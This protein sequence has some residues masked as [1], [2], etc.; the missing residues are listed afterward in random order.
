[1]IDFCSYNIRGLNNKVQ[2]VSDFLST[3]NIS[4]VGLL[5]TRVKKD[6]AKK[7][8]SEINSSFCW[9]D[10]YVNH[11][12]GRI[13][14]GWNHFVWDLK[15]L[16]QSA[17]HITCFM[18]H[19]L[20]GTDF[21]IS[22]VYGSNSAIE[23]RDLWSDLLS[24]SARVKNSAWILSGD[25]NICKD[26]SEKHGGNVCWTSEMGE[27]K[28]AVIRLGITDLRFGGNLFTWCDGNPSAPIFRKLDRTMVNADWLTK[29]G[30]SSSF[31]PNRGFSDHSPATT[32]LGLSRNCPPKPFK[33]F[34]FLCEH[35]DFLTV[36]AQCWETSIVGDPWFVLTSKLKLVKHA[37]K[38]LNRR[39][40]NVHSNVSSNRAALCLHQNSLSTNSSAEY[41]SEEKRLLAEFKAS[42]AVEESFLKQ[43]SRVQWL[44]LGDSNN[45]YFYNACKSKWNTNKILALADEDGVTQ[46]S[47]TDISLVA[48]KYFKNLYS[49]HSA[50]TTIPEDLSLPG[51]SQ[52]QKDYVSKPFSACEVFATLK[53]MPKH[54]A[55]GPDGFTV[56]FF[57]KAWQIVGPDVTTAIL[58]FFDS[59][60]MPRIVNSVAIAL[61]PKCENPSNM[62]DFRPISCCNILYKC[63]AKMLSQRLKC[64]LQSIISPF[65]SAFIPHRSLGDNVMLVQSLCKDYHINRG[66]PRCA[67]K[68]DIHKAFD[69]LNWDF[70]FNA[71]CRMNFP[72]GFVFWIKRCVTSA[73]FSVKINGSLEG[74]F[75]GYSGLRQGDPLSPYLFILAMEVLSACLKKSTCSEYF[76]FHW[77]TKDIGL[78]H[79]IFADD[80]F[81]F[82]RGD[83]ASV[84]CLNEGLSLFS[85]LSGLVP[86]W[87]KSS[88]FFS[89]VDASTQSEIL[90]V[91]GFQGGSLP[92]TYLGLPLITSKL[93]A[94]DCQPLIAKFCSKIEVWTA[95]LLSFAGRL[96]LIKYVLNGILGFWSTYIFLPKNILKRLNA[97]MFKFLW[98]GFYKPTGRCHYKVK[99][100]ECCLP[101][102]EGGLGLRNIFEWNFSAILHQLWRIVQ[103]GSTSI[104]VQWFTKVFLKNKGFWT[105]GIPYKCSWVARKIL[106]CRVKASE[107]I[108]YHIGRNSRFLFWLDPWVQN[109]PLLARFGTNAVS[110]FESSQR[111]L[112]SGFLFDGAWSFPPSNHLSCIEIRQA[113]GSVQIHDSDHVSW[114]SIVSKHVKISSIWNSSRVHGAQVVWFRDVWNL[115]SIPKCSFI[116][117]LALKNRLLTR[118]RMILLE[119]QSPADCV[120]CSGEESAQHLFSDCPFFDLVRRNSPIAFS[121]NWEQC[122]RGDIFSSS[123]DN[124]HRLIGS[125]C[126]AVAVYLTWKERNFRVHNGGPG[127]GS[128]HIVKQMKQIVREKLFSCLK[129]KKWVKDDPNLACVLY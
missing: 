29:F 40:G 9:I 42:L 128:L 19:K 17:Q 125:L 109:K 88:C 75:K 64:V 121:D 6:V 69:S 67:I 71:L 95:R 25:F 58:F 87:H 22:F 80:I 13:W 59:G 108:R 28:D 86:S 39:V 14:V 57:L 113:I 63:I 119:I 85:S 77:R 124:C 43:K 93:S 36:V 79:L 41:F 82:C 68:V 50:S 105:A 24:I 10:N 104:W 127:H 32:D 90:R 112:I 11:P 117:W 2:C 5:E 48:I 72:E 101:L 56:E 4:L 27:F 122:Q 37:L 99:W 46:E 129:F 3:N 94:R 89:A 116:L 76:N 44:K 66:P 111:A 115:F 78:S 103:P 1:M 114:D 21:T 102:Q 18:T 53:S 47:H 12:G 107:Y 26:V 123:L 118:D 34:D 55:P 60:Q 100:Q 16:S 120:F 62:N 8:S 96:I 23:R 33:C 70:I 110:Q 35:P 74:Y 126:L 52:A 65:Q 7:I 92:I 49:S 20:L 91:T 15:I 106:N 61:V 45:K 83:V 38:Q 73:M 84:T 31:F 97:L 30:L 54:R 51:L 98:G 81:L